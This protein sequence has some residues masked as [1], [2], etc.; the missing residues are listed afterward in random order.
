[1]VVLQ[2]LEATREITLVLPVLATRGIIPVLPV[3]ATKA[4][5]PD[6]PALATRVTIPV[7]PALAI[8]PVRVGINHAQVVLPVD[9]D[10]K[11]DLV[12]LLSIAPVAV[13]KSQMVEMG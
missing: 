6:L 12:V 10:H 7:L 9:S 3:Q 1:M 2:E 4:T 5:I 8:S 13:V 11:V